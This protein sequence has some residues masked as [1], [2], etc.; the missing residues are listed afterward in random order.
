MPPVPS[1]PDPPLL[2]H[3][4]HTGTPTVSSGGQLELEQRPAP[5]VASKRWAA[6]PSAGSSTGAGESSAVIP[7]A[8]QIRGPPSTDR[9]GPP[10]GRPGSVPV[11]AA[12][13]VEARDVL[14]AL[15]AL[16]GRRAR[17]ALGGV[18]PLLH[19]APR[20]DV[21]EREE[22]AQL[23]GAAA[24]GVPRPVDRV[25]VP[26]EDVD[27]EALS[28]SGAHVLAEGLSA[29]ENHVIRLPTLSR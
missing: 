7:P 22:V 11:T 23:L 17:P 26:E 21:E 12:G 5:R 4:D 14:R 20:Q 15:P 19:P 18:L 8:E 3:E 6:A 13:A 2:H 29:V 10:S 27:R 24:V 16:V 25:P 28:R 9:G 1:V